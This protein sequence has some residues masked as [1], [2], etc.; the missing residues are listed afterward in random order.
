MTRLKLG[1]AS[2]T[3]VLGTLAGVPEASALP[4]APAVASPSSLG[5]EGVIQDARIVCGPFRCVRTYGYYRR[6]FFRYR[7]P[8]YYRRPFIRVF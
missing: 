3:L 2:A 6:P 5:G 7:R 1:L 8:Y 4:A